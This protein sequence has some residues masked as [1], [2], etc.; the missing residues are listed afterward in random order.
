MLSKA[1]WR[2]IKNGDKCKECDGTG[3]IEC[4]NCASENECEACKGTGVVNNTNLEFSLLECDDFS[5]CI[6]IGDCIYK[7][8]YLF[9]IASMAQMCQ[10]SE[11]QYLYE[12]SDR[13]GIFR[14]DGVDILLMP[15]RKV[16]AN[17]VMRL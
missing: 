11:M 16:E 3:N 12:L 17:A 14:F 9:I 13:A 8:D 1:V 2:R 6:K 15:L 4:E 7:A 5:Y 10:V